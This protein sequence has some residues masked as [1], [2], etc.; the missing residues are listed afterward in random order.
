[1]RLHELLDTSAIVVHA[2]GGSDDV[3]ITDITYDSRKVTPGA[4]YVAIPGTK[5]HGD[6]Y[7][8]SAIEAGAVG[9]I[10]EHAHEDL[11]VAWVQVSDPRQVL[12]ALGKTLFDVDLSTFLTVGVTGT[13]GK[14]TTVYLLKHLLDEVVGPDS[15]W[16]FGTVENLLGAHHRDATLTTPESVDIFR[17]ISQNETPPQALSM[18]VSSHSLDLNRI[19]GIE[20]TIGIWTNLTQDHLDYHA[21]MEEYYQVKKRLF[22]AYLKKDGCAV[23]N[24]DDQYGRRLANEL[25]GLCRVLTFGHAHD[26]F[27]PDVCIVSSVVQWPGT[28]VTIS[29]QGEELTVSS[30]LRGGFNVSNLTA[31]IAAG[32]AL[33]VSADKI[34]QAVISVEGVPGR[35]DRVDIDAPFNVVVDYAHTPDALEN[36]LATLAELTEG[37]LICVFSSGGDRDRTKRPLMG[38]AVANHCDFAIVTTDNPRSEEPEDIIA[39]ILP[40]IPADFDHVVVP[41]R[42]E[43]IRTAL[44]LARRGDVIAITNKGHEDYLEVKGVRHHFNDAEEVI[45]LWSQLNTA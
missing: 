22:T 20:F 36:V 30:H 25:V 18:E 3:E 11:S 13:N 43:A 41:D 32:L 24:T 31:M 15:A 5:V 44:T 37:R 16:M 38:K 6:S 45:N 14:T 28:K 2:R 19:S 17:L 39:E 21:N 23:V 40:G 10:S 9:V 29:H 8:E 34:M 4:L 33:G 1:M 26:D 7:I 27:T 35:M 42:R 12:G